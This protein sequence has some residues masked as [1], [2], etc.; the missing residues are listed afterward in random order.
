MDSAKVVVWNHRVQV[1]QIQVGLSLTLAC[2]HPLV[3]SSS[4]CARYLDSRRCIASRP[5]QVLLN[6]HSFLGNHDLLHDALRHHAPSPSAAD[7]DDQ[8]EASG[9]K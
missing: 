9:R 4:H 5:L 1:Q 2:F 3:L 6:T 8:E 7:L